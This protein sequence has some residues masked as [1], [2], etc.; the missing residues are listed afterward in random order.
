MLGGAAV[1]FAASSATASPSGAAAHVAG[2]SPSPSPT[3]A[4]KRCP[5][6]AR[7]CRPFRRPFRQ[8][9][10]PPG[11]PFGLG[12][13]GGAL[14]AVHGQVVLAKPGGGYETVDIQRGKVTTIS[15]SSITVRSADGFTATYAVTASTVVDAQRDGLGSVKAG[16]QVSVLATVSGSTETATS[17][18][19]ITL[20]GPGH[21]S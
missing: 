21:P 1:A 10:F 4:P 13:A 5:D 6:S 19:D 8:F 18:T 17:I 11:L 7:P 15:E 3:F 16:N 14:G 20:L 9:G 2:T 12:F